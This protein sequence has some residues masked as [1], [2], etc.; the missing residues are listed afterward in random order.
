M[1]NPNTGADN[2]WSEM[3]M[4]CQIM[5][6]NQLP[7]S[8]TIQKWT[9]APEV[10][11]FHI[12]APTNVEP[13][14]MGRADTKCPAIELMCQIVFYNQLPTSDTIHKWTLAPE[15]GPFHINASTNVEPGH[16]GRADTKCPDIELM[17]QIMFYN[18]LSTSDTIH[19]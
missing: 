3:E 4:M 11:L 8:D 15:V 6:Y 14:H 1:W 17:C 19:K 7:T 9:L 2:K 12:D 16:M 10:G 13:G 18:Q 5:F